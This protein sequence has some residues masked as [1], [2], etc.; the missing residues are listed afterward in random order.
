MTYNGGSGAPVLAQYGQVDVYAN[1]QTSTDYQGSLPLGAGSGISIATSST[2]Q[3][4]TATGSGSGPCNAHYYPSSLPLRDSISTATTFAT[5]ISI[6]TTC[7]GVGSRLIVRGHGTYTNTSTASPLI[8]F[9]VGA[10]GNSTICPGTS[11]TTSPSLSQTAS[12]WTL[13]CTIQIN[14]TGAPGTAVA[15]GNVEWTNST[16]TSGGTVIVPFNNNSNGTVNF[17]TSSAET[18][19]IQETATP[20][21]GQSYNLTALDVEVQQ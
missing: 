3:T 11:H 20:V 19:S 21:S 7:I 1:T 4:I 10:G 16:G 2:S 5:T 9:A 6:P 18:V 15:W 13:E 8:A 17:T 12:I 14:T